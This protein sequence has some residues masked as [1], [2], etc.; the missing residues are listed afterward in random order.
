MSVRLDVKTY[1]THLAGNRSLDDFI[2]VII[3]I[4]WCI[5][6]GQ[7]T[8]YSGAKKRGEEYGSDT[9]RCH[10]EVRSRSGSD[11][12]N[13]IGNANRGCDYFWT[14]IHIKWRTH[15]LSLSTPTLVLIMSRAMVS[16]ANFELF[17]LSGLDNRVT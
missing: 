10:V 17:M 7:D 3:G 5:F 12:I 8:R 2:R 14:A 9:D 6:H 13:Q 11:Q 4:V 15:A 16:N 1:A